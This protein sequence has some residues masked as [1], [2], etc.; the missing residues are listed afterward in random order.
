M[1]F[2]MVKLFKEESQ[3]TILHGG[4]WFIVGCFISI[5]KWE[6]NFVSS[7]SEI[8]STTI[9]IRLPHLPTELYD[10]LI[11][12][13]M[14]NK[15]G[16]LLKVEACTSA[17][18]RGRYA[19]ISVQIP[20]KMPV[21]ASISINHYIQ[22]LLYEGE[23]FLCKKCRR[24]GHTTS[25]CSYTLRP[26]QIKSKGDGASMETTTSGPENNTISE[27]NS[28]DWQTG[29]FTKKRKLDQK[30]HLTNAKE[31]SIVKVK[32]FDV[33]SGK[34]RMLS[35]GSTAKP[36]LMCTSHASWLC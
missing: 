34:Q 10:A 8:D 29:H 13:R 35:L 30:N 14:G 21:A 17:A 26:K 28:Q 32:T 11:L 20:L 16:L 36:W 27:D 31:T 33:M 7:S 22:P 19:R 18:L 25:I 5:R 23:G 9:W 24:L 6:P 1:G 4:P 12:Q 2:F 3:S 15:I